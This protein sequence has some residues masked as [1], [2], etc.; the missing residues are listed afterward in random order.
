MIDAGVRQD[1]TWLVVDPITGCKNNCQYC[2]LC[3]YD[4]SNKE[5]VTIFSPT[6]AV[7][8]LINYWAFE[9]FSY[10]MIGTTTDIF[11]TVEN[12]EYLKQFINVY[13]EK[14]ISNPLSISTKCA[15]QDHF[16]D[17]ISKKTKVNFCFYISYSGLPKSIEPNV[18][19]D[20]LI[21]NFKKL[22][23]IGHKAI[24][25]FRPIIPQN[26]TREVFTSVF[27]SIHEYSECTII[28]GLNLND[29]LQKRIWFW[30]EAKNGVFDF[31]KTVSVFPKGWQENL[32]YIKE[33]FPEY[34]IYFTNSCSLSYKTKCSETF[35][36]LG[37][38]KCLSSRC[39]QNHRDLCE[40]QN[41]Q[42]DNLDM[43]F[44]YDVMKKL[45]L[46]NAL[47]FEK[48]NIVVSGELSHEQVAYLSQ[49]FRKRLIVEKI[50][51]QHEWGGHIL[52]HTDLI[53]S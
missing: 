42:F 18:C 36:T 27:E 3:N 46:N 49:K 33:L 43:S 48:N 10:P 41:K 52:G 26:S 24:H 38:E 32:E 39:P 20:N 19:I 40:K 4:Q 14:E 50:F 8:K 51:S 53:I 37:T 15:I 30:E 2:F 12:I 35:G 9:S 34:P 1:N 11:Q 13:E 22:A 17:F 28:R 31:T 16:I 6:E 29:N 25:Q 45:G 47:K 23:S 5:N 7:D 44:Y 21:L